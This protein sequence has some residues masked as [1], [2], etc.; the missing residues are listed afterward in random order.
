[1]LKTRKIRGELVTGIQES[2]LKTAIMRKGLEG[3]SSNMRVL[4]DGG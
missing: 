1:M 3:A 4:S 2:E